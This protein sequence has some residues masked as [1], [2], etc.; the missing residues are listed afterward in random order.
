MGGSGP[1]AVCG[2]LWAG[3]VAG[4]AGA[5]FWKNRWIGFSLEDRLAPLP[6]WEPLAKLGPELAAAAPG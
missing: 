4:A 3:A 6:E 1:A 5:V 2:V